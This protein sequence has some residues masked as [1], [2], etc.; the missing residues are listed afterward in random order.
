MQ[1]VYDTMWCYGIFRTHYGLRGQLSVFLSN[2]L[3]DWY[4]CVH[5]G[6]VF[7][8]HYPQESGVPQGSILS[9]TLLTITINRMVKM[10]GPSVSTLLYVYNIA[11]SCGSWSLYTIEHKLQVAKVICNSG[12]WRT[13]F[14]SQH[15]RSSVYISHACTV[16]ILTLPSF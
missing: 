6:N 4:F 1:K 7:S 16:Y 15:L 9:Q 3:K 8:A 10:V 11:I 5:L 2:F 14:P 13:D 12:L